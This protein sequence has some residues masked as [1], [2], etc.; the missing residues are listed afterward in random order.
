[1]T[2]MFLCEYTTEDRYHPIRHPYKIAKNYL[3]NGYIEHLIALIP[4]NLLMD[5]LTEKQRESKYHYICLLFLLKSLR[6]KRG[7][8]VL[9]PSFTTQVT[10]LFFDISR[11]KKIEKAL[12]DDGYFNP[13]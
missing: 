7:F 3:L 10:K 6:M 2:L 9:D 4:F 12:K 1:M 8:Q 5:P 13:N 11:Q